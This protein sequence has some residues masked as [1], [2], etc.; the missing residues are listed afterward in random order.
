[1]KLDIREDIRENRGEWVDGEDMLKDGVLLEEDIAAFVTKNKAKIDGNA[2]YGEMLDYEKGIKGDNRLR[3]LDAEYAADELV[4][5][6][7]VNRSRKQVTVAFRG[8]NTQKD[9][10]VGE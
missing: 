3:C 9:M 4:Y 8:T 5:G 7:N 6:I 1:M 2:N 10:L